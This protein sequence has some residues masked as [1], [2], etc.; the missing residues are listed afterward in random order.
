M[1]FIN[2]RLGPARAAGE[3]LVSLINGLS[4]IMVA[5]FLLGF[6]SNR[7][8]KITRSVFSKLGERTQS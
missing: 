6:N 3:R 5:D 8:S 1:Q 4:G 7:F 2:S